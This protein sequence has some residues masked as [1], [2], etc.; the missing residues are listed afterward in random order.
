MTSKLYVGVDIAQA[1]FDAASWPAAPGSP[2]VFSN[3]P[4]G[5]QQLAAWVGSLPTAA[6]AQI[7]VVLEPT[8]GYE[9]GLVAFA[10]N[11]GWHVCLP[12]PKQVRDFARGEGR[13]AKT[14]R[15]DARVLAQFGAEKQPQPQQ[16]LPPHIQE[17]LDLLRRRDDLAQLARSE[18]NRLQ[19][20]RQRPHPAAA[21]LQSLERTLAALAAEMVAIE[22]AIDDL[23]QGD[24][25]LRRQAKQLR[26]VPG[27]GKKNVVPILVLLYRWQARTAGQGTAKGLVAFTGL[28][29]QPYDSGISVHKRA[30][31]SRMGDR[32][33]RHYLYMGALGGVRG[34]NA[35]RAFYDRLVSRGK[36]KRV[37]LVAAA[38]KIL[39]WAWAVFSQGTDFDPSRFPSQPPA[40]I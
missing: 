7:V 29:P 11:Q 3:T 23:I 5:F 34:K 39:I 27:I 8:G 15:Q 16:E 6:E 1:K 9:L 38:H 19:S 14:D 25:D 10:Y 35:L 18:S 12:N 28:D 22:Q 31:I 37:A 24:P 36:A 4:A 40:A 13:R 32:S 20:L 30:V 17:L 21:V 26:T 2:A 33:V